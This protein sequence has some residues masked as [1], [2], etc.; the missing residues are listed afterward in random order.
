MIISS[1]CHQLFARFVAT[2]DCFCGA[3]AGT[4]GTRCA[5]GAGAV[6]AR[7]SGAPH[8]AV[9]GFGRC[10]AMRKPVC[11]ESPLVITGRTSGF[12]RYENGEVR[13]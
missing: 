11:V 9:G 7:A 8:E 12:P 5:G 2:R 10:P 4:E 1:F 3:V 6:A 13:L